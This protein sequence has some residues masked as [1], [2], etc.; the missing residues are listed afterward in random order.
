MV[1]GRREERRLL[2]DR[3]RAGSHSKQSLVSFHLEETLPEG[4][5]GAIFFMEVPR[6][7]IPPAVE[8]SDTP[9]GT[10]RM[11]RFYVCVHTCVGVPLCVRTY[12]SMC[13][14]LFPPLLTPSLHSLRII[15]PQVLSA[16]EE[17][18][19]LPNLAILESAERAFQ[20]EMSKPSLGSNVDGIYSNTHTHTTPLDWILGTWAVFHQ[21]MDV[22]HFT[23]KDVEIL[24]FICR[25]TQ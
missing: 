7:K 16:L 3:I 21:W 17:C 25:K 15:C 12:V 5:G 23:M 13:A 2:A 10:Q 11:R 1:E 22:F 24:I 4:E 20:G 14:N 6:K 8:E 18:C 19:L 9:R